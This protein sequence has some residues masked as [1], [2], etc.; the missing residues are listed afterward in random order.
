MKIRYKIGDDCFNAANAASGQQLNRDDIEAAFQR[1]AEYKQSLQASGNIDGMADKLKSFAE[2]EAER[3]RVAAALQKRHAALNILVRDRLDQS[4]TGFI[5]AGMSPKKALLAVLEGTQKGVE[6]G[7]NSVA[8]LNGAYEGRYLGGLLGEMQAERPHLIH[9]LR[10]PRLDIDIMREMAE[11]KE[12]GKPGITGN[13]DA[14]YVAKLFSTYAEMSRTDLNR[15]GASIGKLDGW[16]GAQTHD[17]MK[18]IAAGKESWI[19]SVLPKLDMAKTFPDAGSAKEIEEALSGIYDTLVTGLP[20]KPTPREIGQRVSPA[21]LAKSLGKSRV[22]HFKDAESALAYRD[23]FGYG[24][25][26]SGMV[27]HLRSAAKVAANMEALG[28]N[29]EVM[30]GSLVDGLKRTIKED[31]KLSPA[32]KT[33]RMKGLDADAGSLRHALDIST[34]LISRPVDT[35]AAK[36]GGDIRA[37]QS[38]AKLG[39]AIWSSMS[40]TVTGGLASQFRGSG[41]FKG[42]VNQ[43]D[44]II[45]GRPK[46][47]VAEISYL[48]GEGFDGLIGHIVSPAAAVDGP[49]GRLSKMQETFF[50]WNGLS[51][52]TDI[53]RAAA[54][55]MISAEMGMRAKTAFADLPAAYKHV[56]GLHGIDE[57]KW[58]VIRQAPLREANGNLY[59]TP[60]RIQALP[61]EA[62]AGL[63]K[64]VEAA[65][66]DIEMS[67][68]RF[69][70]DETS[71]GVIETDARSRRTTTWGT[72]P[73][74]LAGEGI[75]FI[76][77][78]KGFP[79]AF[80]QRAIGRAVFGFRKGAALQQTAHIG[81]MLAGLTMAGY[82]AMTMKDLTKG[83]WPP[84]DPADPATWGAAFVQGGA[85]GIYGDYLFGRVNRFGSGPAETAMGPAL[86]TAFDALD[87]IMKARDASISDDEQIK[88]ADWLNFATQNTPY[89]NLYYVRPA[90]DFLFMNS[91]REV[92][93]PGF[94]RRQESKRR[95]T[96]GQQSVMP[97]PLRPFN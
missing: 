5:N 45:H 15:L 2:R 11:L 50:R 81:T 69:V 77:Q 7:R 59:L 64:N 80:S 68:R 12:G 16:A 37:V 85:A 40:D 56:L 96:Y 38:M 29:P 19:A 35:T 57:A 25:T 54:G 66:H 14:Q 23:E 82:A 34:G 44:G 1:M 71:Y 89:A 53:Q 83:Y 97:Q 28:P 62:F 92:A 55:R 70:A 52:W 20:N 36:I 17:D 95:S 43:L 48:L 72:R 65:R 10:D 91:L 78:F 22:L 94:T 13:K 26:V 79:I 6:G 88:L 87:L 24:N 63:G 18:M 32:E 47:E 93:S 39:A 3:T 61:D 84:R 74:T 41:F 60:D 75:R 42:F 27:A 58:N 8:A 76:M 46:G 73:G 51:W 4:V 33:K 21:N 31:A 67:L 30:F 86:G 9:A 49:V 90:L